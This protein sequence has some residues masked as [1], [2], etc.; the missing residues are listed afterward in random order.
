MLDER[1]DK[2]YI[3]LID[4]ILNNK[5][6]VKIDKNKVNKFVYDKI[7]DL[8]DELTIEEYLEFNRVNK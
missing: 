8:L 7:Y 4:E 3:Y 5:L 6:D 2:L 1:I